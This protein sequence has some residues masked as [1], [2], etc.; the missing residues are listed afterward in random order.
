MGYCRALLRSL[1][2]EKPPE[3][4]AAT[5]GAGSFEATEWRT[6]VAHGVNRGKTGTEYIP[7]PGRG[8]R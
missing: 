2:A 4:T 8:G 1:A 7:S 6:P 5:R 3:N